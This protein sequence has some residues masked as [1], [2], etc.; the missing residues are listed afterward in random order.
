MKDR[1]AVFNYAGGPAASWGVAREGLA[2]PM[3][4]EYEPIYLERFKKV[5]R[6]VEA[7][8]DVLGAAVGT[9]R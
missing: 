2:R 3:P 8:L 4:F 1:Q 9:P 7:A 6:G 5:E